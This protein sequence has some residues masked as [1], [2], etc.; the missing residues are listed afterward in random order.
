MSLGPHR[1]NKPRPLVFLKSLLGWTALVLGFSSGLN[2]T[3]AWAQNKTAKKVAK[4]VAEKKVEK[5]TDEED[6]LSAK[7]IDLTTE[8]GLELKATYFPGTK[9]Q[10]SIPVILLH[11]FKDKGSRKD[12]TQEQGLASF[13]QEKLGCS[14]IVPDLRGHG[15]STKIKISSKRTD[16]LKGKKLSPVQISAMVTQDMR[17]VKD[18][19]WE[20]NNEK[21]LNIDKLTVIGLEEGGALAL[22]YAAYDAVGYEQRE[23]KVGPL[24]LGRF[25]K[26]AVLISPTTNIAGLKTPQVMKMPA[27]CRDLPVMIVVG[28]KS[29]EPLAEAE[30]LRSQF[31]NARPPADND[32]PESATVWFFRKIDTPLQGSKLLGEPSLKVPDK[33]LTFMTVWLVKNA[34][35]KDYVW[36]KRNLPHQDK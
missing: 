5:M 20:K 4:K 3:P 22:S 32:K 23:A 33:I 31:V 6:T 10:E 34:D 24:K 1:P 2:A 12:F 18:F 8:D 11:G 29:K 21:A 15:D 7:E 25:V 28:N 13:L 17:A 9:G 14:V 35:A 36:K 27:I 16:D 26:A 30:R 19:L